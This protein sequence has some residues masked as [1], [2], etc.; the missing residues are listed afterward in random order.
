MAELA[1]EDKKPNRMQRRRLAT[2]AKLLDATLK[3]VLKKGIDKTTMDDITETADLGRRTLY[4]HFSSKEE[5]ILAAV[6]VQYERHAAM[7]ERALSDSPDPAVVVATHGRAVLSGLVEEPVTRRLVDYPKLLATALQQAISEFALRDI[8]AGIEQGRF[9]RSMSEQLLNSI[10]IW[11][12]VGLL[13]EC[14]ELNLS[15]DE[16][17]S[18]Y[19][20]TVLT[21]LGIS[22]EEAIELNEQAAAD[23]KR[24][25]RQ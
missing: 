1:A 6:A 7:A 23:L 2:R 20:I 3:L 15:T 21:N 8:N 4:Y 16:L 12:L 13:I 18:A 14:H 24:V 17:M 10:L 25:Q 5:C 9:Q 22:R 11:S 19:A